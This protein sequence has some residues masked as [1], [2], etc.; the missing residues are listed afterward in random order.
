MRD[1][2]DLARVIHEAFYIATTGRPGPVVVDI[3][4][5]VQ[6][7]KAPLYRPR[8]YPPPT[9]RPKLDPDASAIRSAVQLMA[10]AK[11]PVIYS[12]GGIINSGPGSEH[13]A[14]RARAADRLS[15]HLD[16]D[17]A[18]RL[19]ASDKHWLGPIG[20]HGTYEANLAPI[21]AIF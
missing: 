18:G 19:P 21:A 1:V 4:K 11:R 20:M 12:G 10:A 16:P 6:F 15:H 3:P 2:N 8:E 17:G 7:K 5:D 9:Y 14:A 13:A